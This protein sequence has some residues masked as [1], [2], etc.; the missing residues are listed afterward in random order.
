MYQTKINLLYKMNIVEKMRQHNM[1]AEHE[2]LK[3]DSAKPITNFE[4]FK[5][6]KKTLS[7]EIIQDIKNYRKEFP[8]LQ[9]HV[10][11]RLM[12]KNDFK[13]SVI[14]TELRY[15]S[16]LQGDAPR[17]EKKPKKEKPVNQE[18]QEKK[19][20]IQK[21]Q[22][23][24]E[25]NKEGIPKKQQQRNK[26]NN[27]SDEFERRV[28]DN[29]YYE[30]SQRQQGYNKY[31]KNYENSYSIKQD[32]QSQ[33]FKKPKLLNYEPSHYY[34]YVKKSEDN[35]EEEK[36]SIK[37]QHHTSD[38]ELS[39]IN[40]ESEESLH[41]P[42]AGD[43][44]ERKNKNSE[45][46]V[47]PT[48]SMLK[49]IVNSRN[50]LEEETK[51]RKSDKK[52]NSEAKTF[53]P[54]GLQF[55][56]LE[57]VIK[58][59]QKYHDS[60]LRVFFRNLRHWEIKVSKNI[61]KSPFNDKRYGFQESKKKKPA[62]KNNFETD[63]NDESNTEKIKKFNHFI[64]NK[65]FESEEERFKG[66]RERIMESKINEN[67]YQINHLCQK[68][69]G[70]EVEIGNLKRINEELVAKNLELL[71]GRNDNLYCVVPYNMVKNNYPFDQIE[72]KDL[73]ESNVY[74]IKK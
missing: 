30:N 50:I 69:K 71:A 9:E 31:P 25:Q 54:N 65:K 47:L 7:K 70:M 33:K 73:L 45:D 67:A 58:F 49:E 48:D 12:K 26:K 16:S 53:F 3:T 34:E 66:E 6:L 22:P 21:N 59:Y 64:G 13:K 60:H 40:E 56:G 20:P 19:E 35:K 15:F 57:K 8:Q 4:D 17:T 74:I 29:K 68:M 14:D 44:I 52:R 11:H 61:D 42:N 18:I 23:Q 51:S 28:D 38:K 24:L 72:T 63:E 37:I 43:S 2:N 27:N 55:N 46:H 32:N 1:N 5:D 10:I 41:R 39:N 36:K 62:I